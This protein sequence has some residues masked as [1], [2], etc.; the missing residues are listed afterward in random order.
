MNVRALLTVRHIRLLSGLVMFAYLATHLLN[1]ALGVFSMALAESALRAALAVWRNPVA[2]G[3]LY[4]AAA[5]HFALAL[6]TL[7]SRREWH[8]PLVEIV[9]LAAGFSFPLLLIG[10][11]V[12]ARLGHT[13]FDTQPSYESTI[14]NL[15]AAGSQ[16]TQLALLAPG[17]LHGC[18]GLWISLRRFETMQRL[19]PLLVALVVVVPLMAALGFMRMAAEVSALGPRPAAPEY[20]PD[21][22]AALKAWGAQAKQWYLATIAAVFVLGRLRGLKARHAGRSEN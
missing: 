1:H 22:Q 5:I 6:W 8:L 21:N 2:T 14:A 12:S 10:H 3:L 4:G 7:Y 9:R 20:L 11:A 16:G 18:L 13:F 15:L 19:K 17:W